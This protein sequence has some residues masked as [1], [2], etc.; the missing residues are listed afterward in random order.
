[1]EVPDQP[2][3][4]LIGILKSWVPWQS[5]P[6]NVS[7]DFWMPDQSCRVCYEC[8]SQFTLLNRR[9]H[10]RLCG[11]VFCAKCTSHWVPAPSGEPRT[12][13]EEGD[14]IRVC[15]YCFKQ[16]KQGLA[17]TVDNGIHVASMDLSTSPSATSFISTKSDSGTADSSCITLSSMPLSSGLSPKSVVMETNADRQGIVASEKSN[18]HAAHMGDQSSKE[19]GFDNRE[20]GSHPSSLL[21]NAWFYGYSCCIDLRSLVWSSE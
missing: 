18:H 8:D 20:L 4:D 10:C 5:E 15:N 19:Y 14:K 9:H 21:V 16:W 3:S 2:F 13:R 17:A 11:R 6:A 7:R 1:M 12:P